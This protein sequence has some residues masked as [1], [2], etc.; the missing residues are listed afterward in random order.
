VIDKGNE[1]LETKKVVLEV[2]LVPAPTKT[3]KA[4]RHANC[5]CDNRILSSIYIGIRKK[6]DIVG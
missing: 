1:E 5:G 4:K 3:A 2:P 6:L